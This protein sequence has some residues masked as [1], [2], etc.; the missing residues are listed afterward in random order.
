[1]MNGLNGRALRG[2]THSVFAK[3]PPTRLY[4]ALTDKVFVP[5]LL[6]SYLLILCR[7]NREA[8]N[9]LD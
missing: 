7:R 3:D 2:E 5:H 4:M 9:K 6:S 8:Y 1:M